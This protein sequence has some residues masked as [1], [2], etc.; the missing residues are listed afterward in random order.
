MVTVA[1]N[2]EKG[3]LSS[4]QSRISSVRQLH[5]MHAGDYMHTRRREE[6]AAGGGRRREEAA[7]G[8]RR[9]EEAA[10]GWR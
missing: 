6:A 8:G 7:G 10:G 9:W 4:K 5:Y 2:E 1:K 3:D